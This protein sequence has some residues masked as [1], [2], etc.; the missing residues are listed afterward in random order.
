[1]STDKNKNKMS[2]AS[3]KKADEPKTFNEIMSLAAGKAMR[4]GLAGGVAMGANVA[5]LMWMRTTVRLTLRFFFSLSLLFLLFLLVS[6][7]FKGLLFP[8]CSDEDRA[9][10]QEPCSPIVFV[11]TSP[12]LPNIPIPCAP[13]HQQPENRSI[14][15]TVP[16]RRSQLHYGRCTLTVVSPVFIVVFCLH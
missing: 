16:V 5:C 7:V 2:T 12:A 6:N 11:A 13:G 1:M 8:V 10:I 15:N 9:A 4:G 3:T 14:T